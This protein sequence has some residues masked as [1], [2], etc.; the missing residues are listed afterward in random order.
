M[1]YSRIFDCGNK[2]VNLLAFFLLCV[3][4]RNRWTEKG[5]KRHPG[6]SKQSQKR[7]KNRLFHDFEIMTFF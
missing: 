4:V 2:N 1:I 6:D 7:E 3:R 5:L